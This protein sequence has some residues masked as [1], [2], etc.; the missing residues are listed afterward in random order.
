MLE[1]GRPV[2]SDVGVEQ[3]LHNYL[4]HVSAGNF[5]HVAL[6]DHGTR[7]SMELFA[8]DGK[9][10]AVGR[11]VPT[12]RDERFLYYVADEAGDY[13]LLATLI[14]HSPGL[15]HEIVLRERRPA[16]QA[17]RDRERIYN[18][19]SEGI[20]FIYGQTVET[21]TKG[22]ERLSQALEGW[23]ALGDRMFEAMTLNEIGAALSQFGRYRE[24]ADAMSQA[25]SI[26]REIGAPEWEAR[27]LINVAA[28]QLELGEPR[29]AIETLTAVIPRLSD[30]N[31]FYKTYAITKLSASQAAVGDLKV[32]LATLVRAEE[33]MGTDSTALAKGRILYALGDIDAALERYE[34]A[35]KLARANKV[36]PEEFK[37]LAAEADVY[38]TLG[39]YQRSFDLANQ[40]LAA[41]R[42]YGFGG[43]ESQA[44]TQL[45]DLYGD[46]G[47][48][49][50]SASYY[51]D[52]LAV[53]HKIGLVRNEGL[54]Q[55]GLGRVSVAR[56]QFAE[57]LRHYEEAAAAARSIGI[58][59]SEALAARG[60]GDAQ[61][62]AS[63]M[64]RAVA[65]Y[66][67][68][69]DL[70][71]TLGYRQSE[72]VTLYSLG[73]AYASRDGVRATAYLENAL[74]LSRS[75]RDRR[76]T[77]GALYWLAYV[78][79]ERGDTAKALQHIEEAVTIVE[80][81]RSSIKSPELRTSYF[82]TVQDYYD[83]YVDVL[84]RSGRGTASRTTEA[85]R[86][87]ERGRMRALLESLAERGIDLRER[88]DPKLYETE[89][90][91]RRHLVGKMSY[92][93]RLLG[94]EHSADEAA[95]LHREID[96]LES[97]LQSLQAEIRKASPAYAALTQPTAASVEQI[98][99]E[100]DADTALI[101]YAL[102]QE[103][104]YV[105][106]V[107]KT[108]VVSA[109]LPGRE[110]IEERARRVRELLVARSCPV[111][112]ETSE[113]RRTRLGQADAAYAKES[114]ALSRMVLG[115]V[116]KAI[117]GKRLVVVAD[118]A[119]Q[120][121]PF[122]ALPEPGGRGYLIEG[123]EVAMA[124]SATALVAQRRLVAGRPTAPKSV[125]VLADPVFEAMDARVGEAKA[126][127]P[128][129]AGEKAR[130]AAEAVRGDCDDRSG[131]ERLDASRREAEAIGK[132]TAKDDRLEALDFAANLELA[133]SER[134]GEYRMVH[135]A[136]HGFVPPE[137]PEL[138]GLVLSLVDE[139]GKERE[140]YLGLP[141]VY[142][143]KLPA[144]VVT[145]SA[146]ET[147][148]GREVRGEGLVGL[149]RGFM[150][151]GARR[152]VASLWKVDDRET[153][154][155]MAGFYEGMLVEKRRPADALRQA[156]IR[157]I[158]TKRA[159]YFWA[160][161]QLHG[162]WR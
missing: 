136:T 104:G 102:G 123:H 127:K 18:I 89:Q 113:E 106:V 140:G 83:L 7:A 70:F 60:A 161:F 80:A 151:A 77:A 17:D 86:I 58:V 30:E 24:T 109:E 76:L 125:A 6:V 148:L 12:P 85:L 59:E 49:E 145:L 139:S 68:A 129:L 25:A 137:S 4:I 69:L 116:A 2:S 36:Q 16:T 46:I 87:A 52:A 44:L 159:P 34:T 62:G 50:K 65:S 32:A 19:F 160:A 119:L 110:Q 132:L 38:R 47:E 9:K 131:L 78:A 153:A 147:G 42:A 45:G 115:T 135:F 37:S 21:R 35:L 15:R 162:E 57:G 40:A 117:A 158:R 61:A 51:S 118:G 56:K 28:C 79:R 84:M 72:G 126:S 75:L 96:E 94:R 130:A 100:L 122:S 48:L 134:L 33:L 90:E 120:M 3:E 43:S 111:R 124:P 74:A 11:A 13:R 103:R 31:L 143:M 98:Q 95:T 10:V 138:S 1:V 5:V 99:Q 105:W 121:V 114:A 144:E 39:D 63:D 91:A 71:R 142:G 149:V 27:L 146:C 88:V 8:P 22:I 150:Y 128:G 107:T 26:A 133:T 55:M 156:Q 93:V 29:R 20:D 82:S 41:A 66:E 155:L 53:A 152:V 67:R 108:G 97:R 14:P 101:E 73:A 112:H 141:Q 23:R 154:E 157:M 92:Q 54:A 81:L 64:E